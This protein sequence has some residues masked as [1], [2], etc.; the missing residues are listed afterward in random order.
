MKKSKKMFLRIVP[1][2]M[3]LMVVVL[4]GNVFGKTDAEIAAEKAANAA[5]TSPIGTTIDTSGVS[6][7]GTLDTTVKKVWNSVALIL[8][9][10]A[11]AAVVF[12][13]VRYM[14]ASADS[15]ADIKKS[16]GILAVGAILVFGATTIINFIVTL[17][18][19]VI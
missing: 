11:I 4:S 18:G 3:L 16:M 8:Q 19:E 1:I 7:V 12:A 15:K 13:G 2:L 5:A 9:I 17:T 10:L 14:F 6:G